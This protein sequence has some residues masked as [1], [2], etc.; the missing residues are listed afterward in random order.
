MD[1]DVQINRENTNS[2]KYDLRDR[3]FGRDDV[4]PMWVADMEFA[5][6][7]AV[8]EAFQKRIDHGVFGYTLIPDSCREAIFD[9]LK[10]RH[11]WDVGNYSFTF[12]P[13]VVPALN[14]AVLAFTEPGD[15]IIVQPPVYY[16]FFAAA[17]DHGRC[18]LYNQLVLENG[19]YRIDF[20]DLAEKAKGAKMLLLSNPHNPG[21]RVWSKDELTRIA[22]ICIQNDVLVVSDEIHSDLIFNR[23]KHIPFAS[24]SPEAAERSITFMSPS[25]TFNL[26]GLSIAY[27]LCANAEL[28]KKFN[29]MVEHL[30]IGY[31]NIFGAIG[32]E[33]AYRHGEEWLCELLE[34]LSGN[35]KYIVKFFE[36]H[37]PQIK[38]IEPEGTYLV[39]L[40]C[41]ELGMNQK[42][43]NRFFVN[44]A[45]VGLS[46]GRIFGLGGDGF[47]RMNAACSSKIIEEALEKI[48][49]AFQ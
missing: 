16:P 15:G 4:I 21:G 18:L 11:G 13:G 48:K 29:D 22:E 47:M 33:A 46:D 12:S 37:I 49:R 32:L 25:K 44:E 1:F 26:A 35:I 5:A 3:I 28:H 10:K 23:F 20:E 19:K 42:E 45:G 8:K 34:Y 31:C 43:L 17:K 30:H 7:D 41:R 24:I 9:W 40:D 39:W 2:V 36:Q 6:P 14:V 38:V 27:A